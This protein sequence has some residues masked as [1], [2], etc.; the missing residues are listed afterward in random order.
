M[1]NKK[2]F[3]NPRA[4]LL[5]DK[6]DKANG[7]ETIVFN[8]IKQRYIKVNPAGYKILKVID[9]NPGLQSSQIAFETKKSEDVVLKFIK[10]MY[11]ENIVLA[12]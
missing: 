8:Q 4:V 9:D 3:V 11:D 12:K 10:Q 6:I 2:F 5:D 1:L 7:W